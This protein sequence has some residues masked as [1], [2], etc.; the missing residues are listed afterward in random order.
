MSEIERV[1][2]LKV[3]SKAYKLAQ[4][5]ISI[6][7]HES[8][9]KAKAYLMQEFKKNKFVAWE[10][11]AIADCFMRLIDQCNELTAFVIKP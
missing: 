8:M 4:D 6:A 5:A 1:Y 10:Q 7:I 11:R 9:N 3:D 2:G